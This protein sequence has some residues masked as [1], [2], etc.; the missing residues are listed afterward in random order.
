[1]LAAAERLGYRPNL[2]ARNLASR[3]TMTIGVLL[4][5]LHNPFFAEVADGILTAA[6]ESSYR[7]LFS[8]GRVRPAIESHA[9]EAFLEL[10]VDGIVLVGSRLPRAA[11]EAAARTV[12]LVAVGR[13]LRSSVVDTINNHEQAGACLAVDHLAGLGHERIVHIDGGRGAGSAPRRSGYRAAM[14]RHGLEGHV[15]VVGGDLTELSGVRAVASLVRSDDL[16]TAIFAANDLSAAG[17]LDRLGGEGLRVPEDVS[18]VGYDNTGLA[19]MHHIGLTT[20]D[21]PRSK[22]G[23]QS[24]ATLLQRI[25][26][27]RMPA[28]DLAVDPSL[29]VRRTTAP[30]RCS[31]LTARSASADEFTLRPWPGCCWWRTTRTSAPRSSGCS[32]GRVTTSSA[33]RTAGRA[34]SGPPTSASTCWCSTSAC[35]TSKGSR[36]AARSVRC[37]P[38]S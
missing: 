13:R 23:R 35:R 26:R 30:P 2:M 29:V 34:S 10:R 7:V 11:I 27:P 36:S 4:N 32:V 37:A 17:A 15:R 28:V 24:V 6:D 14:A 8:T 18:L 19:A 21:Q 1:M 3:R 16:P 38:G 9:L 25:D 12:P 5:D 33:P 31:R 20:I 22:M